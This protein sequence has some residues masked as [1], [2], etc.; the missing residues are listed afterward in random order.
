MNGKDILLGASTA[1]F[2]APQFDLIQDE[3][4]LPAFEEAVAGARSEIDAI[5]SCTDPPSF[6]N[7]I[8][9]LEYAGMRLRRVEGLFFNL[10]EADAGTRRQEIAEKVTPMLTEY[11]MYVSH[12]AALF[13]RVRTVYEAH[14]DLPATERKLLRDTYRSFLHGGAGLGKEDQEAF[15]V[16]TERL[17]LSEL[18]FSDHILAATNGFFLHLTREEELAGL[19]DFVVSAGAAEAR[20]RGLEGWVF[21][22]QY[23]SWNPFM[24]YSARRDL[25]EKMYRAYASRCIGGKHDN[26]E[27]ILEIVSLRIRLARLLGYGTYA[28]YALEERMAGK[29]GTVRTF[30][31]QLMEPSLPKAR[32]EVA[33]ILSFARERGFGDT[34]LR[35]WDFKY[36]AERYKQEHYAL[37]EAV[38]KPYFPLE[39]CV[40]AAFDLAGRL[41]GLQFRPR[42]DVPAYHPEVQVYEVLDADGSHLALFYTDFF[43]RASKRGGAWMTEFRGQ[44]RQGDRDFRPFV[45]IVTN[46]SK[47]TPDRP[48]LLTHDELTTLL[49]EFG[50]SLHGM[51]SRG[52]Y[53]SMCGTEVAR[54]FVELPSQLMENWAY[55]PDF[56]RTFAF[57]Y[58]TGEPLP[59][60]EIDRIVA[61]KNY[62]AAYYQVRQLQFGIIDLAWHT[63]EELPEE[64]AVA[65]EDRILGPYRTL[66]PVPGTALSP[67]FGHIFSGGYSAGYYSYKW[68]EVLEADAFEA[69][70]EN[71]I[72]DRATADSF[73]KN[74]LERGSSEDESVLYRRFRGHDPQPEALLRK[75]GII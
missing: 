63:L 48:S 67:T 25:R 50:H 28:D 21:T 75:L 29:T 68:A 36:W 14:P 26:T 73:R 51:L 3:D 37:D 56:L 12:N 35:A 55:E 19:P 74:I 34:E 65:F 54:D 40:Q 2:G 10:L 72:F 17:S 49:H 27:I 45:S 8:A 15:A 13:G 62:L 39:R 1:P 18:R 60:V 7:T 59:Q 23:P 71:G 11:S 44:Y 69:F 6:D 53:P 42:P 22:L 9:A 30:L 33:R 20:E 58:E 16:A 64:S 4:V 41:Y 46:F 66:S 61:A 31:A 5:A 32:Q 47:P 57:H 70:R 38:L 52:R 43:P 24:T